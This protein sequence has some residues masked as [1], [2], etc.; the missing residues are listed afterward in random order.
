MMPRL[1]A[2]VEVDPVVLPGAPTT[3]AAVTHARSIIERLEDVRIAA[4]VLA[5]A[6]EQADL[7]ID[8]SPYVAFVP[9]LPARA[10][11][12]PAIAAVQPLRAII[13]A[14]AEFEDVFCEGK[15]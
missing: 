15:M 1:P 2:P 13:E 10:W 12:K 8:A 4:A 11:A 5:G 6:A 7:T 14:C 3:G 9:I